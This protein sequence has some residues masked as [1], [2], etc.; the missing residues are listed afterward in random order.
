MLEEESVEG[1]NVVVWPLGNVKTI[2]PFVN[3]AENPNGFVNNVLEVDDWLNITVPDPLVWLSWIDLVPSL[4][5]IMV[6]VAP[7]GPL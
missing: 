4:F 3:V 5:W 2:F 1:V 7:S 6:A